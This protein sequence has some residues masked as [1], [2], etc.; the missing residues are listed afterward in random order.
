MPR[1]LVPSSLVAMLRLSSTK[2]ATIFW[3]GFSVATL[4]AGC[5]NINRSSVTRS[6]CKPHTATLLGPRM[7]GTATLR[8][9]QMG[10]PTHAAASSAT[11]SRIQVGHVVKNTRLPFANKVKGYLKRN[12]NMSLVVGRGAWSM[13]LSKRQTQ[14][15]IRIA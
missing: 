2:T 11:R 7:E 4:S 15:A 12:S 5:H 1:R 13:V 14:F 8:L 9:R 3:R 6:A 10:Q